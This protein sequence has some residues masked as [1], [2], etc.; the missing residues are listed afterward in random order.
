MVDEESGDANN[1]KE[2]KKKAQSDLDSSQSQVS[3]VI[4]DGSCVG[5]LKILSHLVIRKN[6]CYQK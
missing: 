3:L 6:V 5:C 4:S 1:G 2:D